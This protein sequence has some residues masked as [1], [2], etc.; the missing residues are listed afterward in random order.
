[1]F[2]RAGGPRNQSTRPG[3]GGASQP[4]AVPQRRPT[5][6]AAFEELLHCATSLLQC[7]IILL[8][9]Y[10][11]E[12]GWQPQWRRR[13]ARS[14]PNRIPCYANFASLALG[15]GLALTVGWVSLLGFG[16]VGLME[17]TL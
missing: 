6:T 10:P 2:E 17:F 3:A 1:L 14:T 8:K 16:I 13:N 11:D 12:F 4:E 7:S 9:W 5:R 15:L